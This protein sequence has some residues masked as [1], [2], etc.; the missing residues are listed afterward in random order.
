MRI[1]LDE[2]IPK[3][4]VRSL[5]EMVHDVR[6]LRGTT[7]EGIEDEGLPGGFRFIT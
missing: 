1:L 2:N 3:I 4:P 5:Q 6:D 7:L